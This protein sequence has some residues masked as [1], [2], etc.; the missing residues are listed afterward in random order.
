MDEPRHHRAGLVGALI[1]RDAAPKKAADEIVFVIKSARAQPP[2]SGP[3]AALAAAIPLEINGRTSP[4]TTILRAGRSYR[5]RFVGLAVGFPNA[6]AW[7]TERPDSSFANLSDSMV[8]QWRA[9]GEDGADLPAAARRMQLARQIISMGE[10]YDFEFT[11][12]KPGN[13]RL[14]V[15]GAGAGARLL[16]RAPI[17]V[18]R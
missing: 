14:E 9:V 17:R 10:T 4:D 16:V 12:A 8:V 13:L 5:F 11:P 3:G 18:E 1:V 6:T 7:L 2:A 15:R